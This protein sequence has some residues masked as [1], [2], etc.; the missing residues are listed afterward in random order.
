MWY[1][2]HGKLCQ[3]HP[4]NQGLLVL[5]FR[6]F[7]GRF[8]KRKNNR[9][10]SSAMLAVSSLESQKHTKHQCWFSHHIIF[11]GAF[12]SVHYASRL[13]LYCFKRRRC[14]GNQMTLLIVSRGEGWTL[15][16]SPFLHSLHTW[17]I[18]RI[19]H[20]YLETYGS[21]RSFLPTWLNLQARVTFL[22]VIPS[23]SKT[24]SIPLTTLW[25]LDQP[26]Y[27]VQ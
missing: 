19:Y 10:I 16:L 14:N 24:K 3:K 5:F 25:P 27:D 1:Q 17:R 2:D 23:Y 11:G 20:W 4:K 15:S 21:V 6:I 13:T 8:G 22:H 9:W 7:Q 12:V 18:T 26:R